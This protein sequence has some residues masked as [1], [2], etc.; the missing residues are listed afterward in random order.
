[1]KSCP[2]QKRVY[3]S[4]VQAE[5]ALLEMQGRVHFR[6][7]EGP[8]GV[9]QCDLCGGYHL[10]SKGP[11]N[12]SLASHLNEGSIA[13]QREANYWLGKLKGGR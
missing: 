7:G 11:V 6:P 4:A 1:M 13:L 5:Q 10:T 3:D 2:T 9:Y 12:A 8:V